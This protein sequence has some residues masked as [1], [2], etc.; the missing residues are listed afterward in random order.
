MFPVPSSPASP[1]VRQ[2]QPVPAGPG[3]RGVLTLALSLSGELSASAEPAEGIA[4]WHAGRARR[5]GKRQAAPFSKLL[6]PGLRR[7]LAGLGG[8]TAVALGI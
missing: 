2:L 6:D 5:A 7:A 1:L 3:G 8:A 4:S